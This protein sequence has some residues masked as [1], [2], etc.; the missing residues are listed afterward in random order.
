VFC[1]CTNPVRRVFSFKSM[2]PRQ[3]VLVLRALCDMLLMTDKKVQA[4]IKTHFNSTLRITP[5]AYDSFGRGYYWTEGLQSLL[6]CRIYRTLSTEDHDTS[7]VT[8]FKLSVPSGKAFDMH[9]SWEVVVDGQDDLEKLLKQ[10]DLF[11]TSKKGKGSELKT[12]LEGILEDLV[13]ERE[14][15]E[16]KARLQN[17]KAALAALPRRQSSRTRAGE[18]VSSYGEFEH[19]VSM[20]LGERGYWLVQ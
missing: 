15:Y 3:R 19:Y 12:E 2:V 20:R 4:D 9:E 10:K 7:R 13:I 5:F 11:V 18:G 8:S 6:S 14:R 16:D 1:A 17:K